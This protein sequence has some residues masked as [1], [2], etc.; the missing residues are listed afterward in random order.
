MAHLGSGT[1]IGLHCLLYLVDLPDGRSLS[2]RDLA[3]FQGVSPSYAAKL[4]TLLEKAGIVAASEG[5]VGGF[6]LARAAG[7]IS[8]GDA[9]LA[10]EGKKPLFQCREIR[11]RCAIAESPAPDWATRAPCTIHALMMTA[12]RAMLRVLSECSLAELAGTVEKKL[13]AGFGERK[14]QWFDARRQSRR[15]RKGATPMKGPDAR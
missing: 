14:E 3:D 7:D 2:A 9:V 15:R 11:G 6:R 8:V 4:F 5:I 13:P 10:I 1:E 12:E